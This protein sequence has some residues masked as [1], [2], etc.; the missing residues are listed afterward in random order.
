LANDSP[1]QAPS[2]RLL[3]NPETKLYRALTSGK[4]I[5]GE[6]VTDAAFRLR[7][8][9]ANF[10]EETTLSVALTPAKAMGELDCKGYTY[11]LVADVERIQ[12]LKIQQEESSDPDLYEIAGIPSDNF[13]AQT[14][15]AIALAKISAGVVRVPRKVKS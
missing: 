8:A 15:Y 13:T 6:R 11:I 10:P 9:N 1:P 5:Q 12:G 2:Q 3:L 14:D 7:P 4:C